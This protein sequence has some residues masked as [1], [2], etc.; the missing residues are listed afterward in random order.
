M[1]RD[2]KKRSFDEMSATEQQFLEDHKTGK[3][4]R[5]FI[6]VYMARDQS[7]RGMFY[8]TAASSSS[9]EE[10]KDTEHDQVRACVQPASNKSAA[11]ALAQLQNMLVELLQTRIF[12][13]LRFRSVFNLNGSGSHGAVFK[14]ASDG[15]G[16]AGSKKSNKSK[17]HK[18]TQNLK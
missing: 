16:S 15:S 14:A 5:K 12:G 6:E 7:F 13:L 17:T 1:Q 18:T 8:P 2:A 4:E 10:R 11:H 9:L 3:T